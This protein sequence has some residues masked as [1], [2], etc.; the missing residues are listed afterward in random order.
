M[1]R[2]KKKPVAAMLAPKSPPQQPAGPRLWP[3]PS[4]IAGV[5]VTEDSALTLGSVWACVRVISETLAALPCGVYEY[6]PT[7]GRA[8]RH[9]DPADWLLCCQANPEMSSFV[10]EETLLAWALTW[11]NGYAEIERDTAG[12]PVWLWPLTPDRVYPNRADVQLIQ[13]EGLGREGIRPGDIVYR[14]EN[15]TTG[16]TFLPAANVFHLRGLGYD[17]LVGYSV[18][19]MAAR[20]IGLGISLEELAANFSANDS[21]PGGYLKFAGKLSEP[22]RQNL[23]ESW[24]R[25]HG[26][27]YR[28]RT[29]A[30][31]EEGLDWQQA[32]LPP[33]DAQL[34]EQRQATPAEICRWF[35]VPPHKIADL[36]RATFSN[37]TDQNEEFVTDCLTPWA[38]RFEAEANFKLFGRTNRGRRFVRHNF[39]SLLRGDVEKRSKYYQTMFDRGIFSVNDILRSEDMNPLGPEGDQHFVPLNMQTLAA[40]A[41]GTENGQSQ[42]DATTDPGAAAAGGADSQLLE[43]PE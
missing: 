43:V 5:R 19:R 23:R 42:G 33:E 40:A 35:R 6:L 22:A 15:A 13:D 1:S 29:V 16:P 32:G 25:V 8:E 30:I 14:V 21:T 41:Q 11:G 38:V 20:S 37:I 18:I 17:G 4:R 31:L 10:W 34:V 26:G 2:R 3:L 36:S 9:D 12:R 39:L 7:G 24:Q 27:P 28:R